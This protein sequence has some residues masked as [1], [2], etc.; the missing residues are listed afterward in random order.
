MELSEAC[1][2]G[3]LVVLMCLSGQDCRTF[4]EDDPASSC[5]EEH[6]AYVQACG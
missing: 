6:A 3:Y 5:P 2:D 1:A 4:L